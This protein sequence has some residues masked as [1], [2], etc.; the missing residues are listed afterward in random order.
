MEKR[1]KE[2]ARKDRQEDKVA[3]RE[4]RKAE[5]EQMRAA[6]IDPDLEPAPD[7]VSDEE[8]ELGGE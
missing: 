7:D 6:G 8:T 4:R 5:R 3:R 1:R 2:Q